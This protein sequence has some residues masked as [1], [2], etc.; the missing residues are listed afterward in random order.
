MNE[1][2]IAIHWSVCKMLGDFG[3]AGSDIRVSRFVFGGFL[4]AEWL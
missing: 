1:N 4:A 2:G 3:P